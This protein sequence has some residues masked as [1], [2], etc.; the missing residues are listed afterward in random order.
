MS[1]PAANLLRFGRNI[2][3]LNRLAR[4]ILQGPFKL[5]S[6]LL[7]IDIASHDE[8]EIVRHIAE[9]V[10]SHHVVPLKFVVDVEISDDGML[11]GLSEKTVRSISCEL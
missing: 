6:H 8:G 5:T 4:G 9:L 10:I 11:K 7:R 3:G 1:F 2:N